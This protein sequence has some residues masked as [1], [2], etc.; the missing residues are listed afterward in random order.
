MKKVNPGWFKKGKDKR[1]HKFTPA[2]CNEG[3]WAAIES[4]AARYPNAVMA[5]GRHITVNFLKAMKAR[6]G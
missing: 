6:K 3:F 2:E 4:V 5:D 1:R